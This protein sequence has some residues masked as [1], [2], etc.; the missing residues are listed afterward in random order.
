[1]ECKR[2]HNISFIGTEIKG[3]LDFSESIIEGDAFLKNSKI[4]GLFLIEKATFVKV[5]AQEEVYRRAK[6]ICEEMGDKIGADE[7]Y[8]KEMVA[9]RRQKTNFI[10][11]NL[12][13]LFLEEFFCYGVKP[14][15]AFFFWLGIISI[16]SVLF[17][18]FHVVD[19]SN[20][21]SYFIFQYRQCH[22][23]GVWGDTP[24]SVDSSIN[25]LR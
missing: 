24:S 20:P 23:P 6:R 18:G 11:R 13:W 3:N 4:N 7:Y 2:I 9:K 12:E 16:F 1:M 22:E 15:N 17:W 19:A 25:R 14:R 21:F 5:S 8:F 10:I